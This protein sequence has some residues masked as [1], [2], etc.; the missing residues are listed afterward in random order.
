M[1]HLSR[2]DEAG[3]ETYLQVLES[4]G[5]RAALRWAENYNGP[6]APGAK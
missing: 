6:A 5:D 1:H 4:Q 2:L 3:L